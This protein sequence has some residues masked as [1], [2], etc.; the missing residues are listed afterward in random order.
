MTVTAS[1]DALPWD[2]RKIISA[3]TG[4]A[5]RLG[6][7]MSVWDGEEW[8]CGPTRN[9]LSVHREI[10]ATDQTQIRF[11]LSVPDDA[12]K[13]PVVGS[14]LLVH[15]NGCDVIADHT[16]NDAIAALLAPAFRVA[17]DMSIRGVFK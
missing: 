6:Y 13:F 1:F 14:V 10:G 3:I 11:R 5:E 9:R 12:G 15:G 4:E 8:A 2:E 7:S 16:D 17:D